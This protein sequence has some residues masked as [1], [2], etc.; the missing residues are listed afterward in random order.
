MERVR[1]KEHLTDTPTPRRNETLRITGCNE[2]L[3][4]KENWK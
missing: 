2:Y 4:G 3:G 1:V